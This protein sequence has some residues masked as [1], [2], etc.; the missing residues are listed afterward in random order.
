MKD[1]VVAKLI[2][3]EEERPRFSMDFVTIGA[4]APLVIK[5]ERI[6]GASDPNTST[7]RVTNL[8]GSLHAS[9]K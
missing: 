9:P 3:A 1:D 5:P 7:A 4:T 8:A 2:A 6:V